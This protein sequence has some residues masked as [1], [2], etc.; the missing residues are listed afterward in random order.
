MRETQIRLCLSL[1]ILF[2]LCLRPL[3]GF[4]VCEFMGTLPSPGEQSAYGIDVEGDL[5]F[6]ADYY[7]GLGIHDISQPFDPVQIAT[8]PLPGKTMAVAVRTGIAYVVCGHGS[9]FQV[10]DCSSPSSPQVL[11]SLATAGFGRTVT[12]EGEYAYIGMNQGGLQVVDIADPTSPTIVAHFDSPDEVLGVDPEGDFIYL[13]S[14]HSG[15]LVLDRSNF[16]ELNLA[17]SLDVS[18][19]LPIVW[20]LE[21]HGE[22]LLMAGSGG[23]LIA[24][25]SNPASPEIIHHHPALYPVDMDLIGD[26]LVYGD[27]DNT[28]VILDLASPDSPIEY[29]TIP[30]GGSSSEAGFVAISDSTAYLKMNLPGGVDIFDLTCLGEDHG[31]PIT[32]IR[33]PA[34]YATIAQAVYAASPGDTILVSPGTYLEHD[35]TC[36]LNLTIRGD[37]DAAVITVSAGRLGRI[38]SASYAGTLRLENL[39]LTEGLAA[40]GGAVHATNTDLAIDSCRLLDNESTGAGGAVFH[41][42]TDTFM[43]QTSVLNSLIADNAA[44]DN[45]GGIGVFTARSNLG[46]NFSGSEFRSNSSG[47][48]GG[49]LWAAVWSTTAG[50]HDA[51]LDVLVEDCRFWLNGSSGDGGGIWVQSESSTS[52]G[53]SECT[54]TVRGSVFGGNE[55]V[56]GGGGFACASMSPNSWDTSLCIAT[57]ESTTFWN[58]AAASG[59]AV[60]AFEALSS[61]SCAVSIANCIVSDSPSGSGVSR[62]GQADVQAT[63][64]DFSGNLPG[65]FGGGI[66]DQIGTAGNIAEDPGFCDPEAEMLGLIAGSPCLPGGNACG[67]LM[68]ALGED[69]CLQVVLDPAGTGSYPDIQS[70]LDAMASGTIHLADGVFAGPGNR[71]LDFLGKSITLRSLSGDPDGCVID[72]GGSPAEPHRGF[73]FA[74]GEPASARVENIGIRNGW[75]EMGGALRCTA[76]AAPSFL[77]CRFEGC[78]AGTG[79]AVH[80]DAGAAPSF[81]S[82]TFVN[83][84]ANQVGGAIYCESASLTLRHCTL[85][86]NGAGNGLA[87]GLFGLDTSATV[88]NSLLAYNGPGEAVLWISGA[89]DLSCSD[90]YGNAGGDWTGVIADQLDVNGNFTAH[91]R[92]C[93][94]AVGLLTL[95]SNSPCLPE[96]NACGTLVGAL[97]EGCGAVSVESLPGAAA[98]VVLAGCYPNP[99][100][101]STNIRFALAA[102]ARVDLAVFDVG[103][104]SIC[105]LVPGLMLEAGEY[106]R[107][108]DGRDASGRVCSSGVYFLRLAT[109]E[110]SVSERLVML[111]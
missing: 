48:G 49:G 38:F 80:V 6:T 35:I 23:I 70:A 93:D 42:T 40:D 91:P 22:R 8:V 3:P 14:D 59:G 26:Y 106:E 54:I 73:F 7:D 97:G 16:P 4:A 68:G 88:E 94:L 78:T 32:T 75:A 19:Y 21:V 108:W 47:A 30:T 103:G 58:N 55:A 63:C 72:C 9:S 76:G 100:N 66:P 37:G 101:P 86:G 5:L 110:S 45:G 95:G 62:S 20:N 27:S 52:Y 53:P 10:I 105:R 83:N 36:G 34:D 85:A 67:V 31:V 96:N 107:I 109:P 18:S 56:T 29:A 60:Y 28:L 92:F 1:S 39:T 77:G 104:R 12:L 65:P 98:P 79:G 89:I 33:V 102:P 11:A 90:L 84:A 111:K 24:D 25:L 74:S 2:I 50:S 13:A 44:A 46:L 69:D 82:T 41:Y 43:G 71:D 99:F 64:S 81:E 87:G 51:Y 17:G 15:L 61:N 57:L